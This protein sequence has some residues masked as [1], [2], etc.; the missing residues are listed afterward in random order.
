MPIQQMFFGIGAEDDVFQARVW[1]A[2]ASLGSGNFQIR[3]YPQNYFQYS[4]GSYL[5]SARSSGQ[6]NIQTTDDKTMHMCI[7]NDK[8]TG[9]AKSVNMWSDRSSDYPSI[10]PYRGS[11]TS[12][13]DMT[14]FIQA[15]HEDAW[16]GSEASRDGRWFMIQDSLS[17]NCA[18]LKK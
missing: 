5:L 7:T 6:T 14:V 17:N 4:D 1:Q 9:F 15:G 16:Q 13:K 10:Y 8:V 18:N 3:G 12:G 11:R 2:A